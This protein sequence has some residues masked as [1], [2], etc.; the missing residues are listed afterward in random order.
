M[1]YI[2][3]KPLPEQHSHKHKQKGAVS[4]ASLALKSAPRRVRKSF[5]SRM[6]DLERHQRR[7]ERL[8]RIVEHLPDDDFAAA[9]GRYMSALNAASKR[10]DEIDA[11]IYKHVTEAKKQQEEISAKK[12][13]RH[14]R[15]AI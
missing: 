11:D 4:R 14:Q 13:W 3:S 15:R 6:R 5:K 9:C 10:I 8:S 2:L 7:Y 12:K 1:T